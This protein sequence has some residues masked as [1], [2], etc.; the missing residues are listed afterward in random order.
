ADARLLR[1]LP[2][3]RTALTWVPWTHSRLAAASGYGA[4]VTSPGWYHHLFTAPDRPV[5]RWLASVAAVLREEDLPASTA[6][7]LEAVRLAEALAALRGRP[8]AGLAEVTE[9]TRA[10]LCE[11]DEAALA[12]V[13]R[14]LVV[15][16]ALGSVPPEAPAVPLEADLRAAARALRLR[17]DPAERTLDLD[18]RRDTDLARSHLLHRLDLLRVR[19]GAPA[20]ARNRSAGTF[21][22]SWRLAWRPEVVVDL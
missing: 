21:R 9:A 5:A 19:W 1:G 10:V 22:E 18:L 3:R 4:G 11:G 14:R 7:V 6:H 12:L 15:G 17:L 20:Q 16:E 8:L 2:K 13:A